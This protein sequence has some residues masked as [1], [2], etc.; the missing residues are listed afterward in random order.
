[1]IKLNKLSKNWL[2]H[3]INNNVFER[4]KDVIKGRVIDLG[5]GE[6]PYKEDILRHADEYIGVDWKKSFHD[7][8]NA[9]VFADLSKALPFKDGCADTVVSFQ[10]LEH[11]PE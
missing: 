11:L 1:M 8:G 3:K 10:V 9:G 2:I 4:N 7:V 5:C 6:S